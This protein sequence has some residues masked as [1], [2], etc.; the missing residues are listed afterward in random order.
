MQIR[1]RRIIAMLLTVTLT[2]GVLTG[3]TS[4]SS[5]ASDQVRLEDE[6]AD[7]ESTWLVKWKSPDLRDEELISYSIIDSEQ[8]EVGINV[9]RPSPDVELQQWLHM[10]KQSEYVDY[11]EQNQRVKTLADAVK[12]ND[13]YVSQQ[14]YL[15]QIKADTAWSW[16][17][18]S[19]EITIAL[20]DTGVD[21][22]HPDLKPN[23]VQGVNLLDTGPPIDDNGHGTNVAGILAAI[24]NNGEGVAGVTWSANI[25]PIKALDARGYGDEDKLGAGILYAVDHGAKIVVM[26]VGLYRYSKYMQD[27][28]DY[29]EEKGVLLIAATGNDGTRYLD[30]IEV[31]YPAAYPSVLAVGGS[32]PDLDVEQR[33]NSGPEVDIVAPW[34]VFTTAMGGGYRAGEGTSMS[35]PQVAG[36]AALVWSMYP[37][38]K[39][40]QIR[41]HLRRTAQ[42][43]GPKGWDSKSGYGL[44]RADKAV[45]T[46]PETDSLSP[47]P[48]RDKARVFPINTMQNGMITSS[49]NSDWYRVEVPY[50]GILQ[51]DYSRISGDGQVNLRHYSGN[52][53]AYTTYSNLGEKSTR[54]R[55][56]K[57]VQYLQ[58]QSAQATKTNPIAYKIWTHMWI[59]DD[60]FEPND[61]QYE[62]YNLAPRKQQV[63]ATFSH[64]GD[65]DWYVVQIPSK[66]TLSVKVTTDT[67]RIDPQFQIKGSM[68][69]RP[70]LVDESSEGQAE[71][72]VLSD[73]EPGKLYI[74]VENAV[75]PKAEAVAGEYTLHLDFLKQYS[76]PNE[77]ND[78]QYEAVTVA[79]EV[80]YH[81]VFHAL[82][83]KDWFQIRIDE[84]TYAV[85]SVNQI[86]NDRTVEMKVLKNDGTALLT[87]RND[88]RQTSVEA[89][90]L[91]DKGTYYVQLS[92]N[93]KFDMQTYRF[94]VDLSTLIEGMR[95]IEGHW[96][97]DAIVSVLKKGWMNGYGDAEF[98]PNR[99]ITR[100]EAATVLSKVFDLKAKENGKVSFKDVSK[101]HWAYDAIEQVAQAGIANGYKPG[102]F[103]PNQQVTRAEMAVMFG[104]AL[105]LKP[106]KNQVAPFDDVAVNYWAAPML[107]EMK[108][109]G[110]LGGSDHNLF[111][112]ERPATRAEF[113]ALLITAVGN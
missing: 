53:T 25:M 83:D 41:E 11:A 60:P 99:T 112:P 82:S 20:V 66:G 12:P 8:P 31:K 108:A 79:P 72:T 71:M 54:I 37:D 63:T 102:L 57:G 17:K 56:N 101:K 29:A 36:V 35:A 62:A 43:I 24:G 96:A 76:D 113:A 92:T 65:E 94:R 39:P 87:G 46:K 81:G 91:L 21:M 88:K 70:K 52:S 14:Q 80:D 107:A 23:L 69:D 2:C 59:A 3:C 32:T 50:D 95:D 33:S 42:D 58:L 55:V 74:K 100:A 49:E 6:A 30:K 67:V 73:L 38:M 44:L 7:K 110:L 9:M 10:L 18:I 34:N 5:T 51:V 48:T 26:S 111:L 105:N 97:Q 103:G 90:I 16:K 28:V 78:R 27:I 106:S 19:P 104:N 61:K 77:P 22:D 98:A 1:W 4:W 13:P 85:F 75:T 40:Y 84:P 45:M 68:L 15:K 64:K 86:P 89:G 109:K 93:E 47:N